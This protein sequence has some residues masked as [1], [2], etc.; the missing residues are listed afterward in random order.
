VKK[1]SELFKALADETRLRILALLTR[2]ELCV[3][4]LTAV[5]GV[6]QSKASRHLAVLRNAGLVTDRRHGMWVYYSLASSDDFTRDLILEWLARAEEAIPSAAEDLGILDRSRAQGAGCAACP[7]DTAID[8]S[9][10]SR[11]AVGK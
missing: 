10:E 11:T 2:G 9:T 5:L 3:C 6:G 4:E 8:S 1:T 7:A